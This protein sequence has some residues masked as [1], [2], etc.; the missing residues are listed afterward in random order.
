MSPRVSSKRTLVLSLGALTAFGPLSLDMYLPGLPDLSRDLGTT[1]SLAQ[2]TLTACMLGLAAG[3]LVAGPV[4]DARGRRA[5]LLV[6]LAAYAI[7][8]LLCALAP[9]IWVLIP[10]RF[11]QGF[12]GAAGIV[13]AR[14]IV[15]D[16]HTGDDAARF[17]S[18]L[19][20]VNGLAP[21]LAPIVGGQLLGV[22]DWRG[23]FVVLA[24][25]GVGLLFVGWRFVPETLAPADRHGGG[26]RAT[27]RVFGTLARDRAF[28]GYAL[29]AGCC[30]A[31]MFC[32]IAGS[33]FVLQDVFGL[34][35]QLFSVVFAV[36]ALGIVVAAQ[37]GARLVGRF[38][39]RRMLA[40]GLTTSGAGAAGLL[41]AVLLDAGLAG[42][43]PSFLLVVASVGLV[44]PNATALAL[45]GEPRIAGSA[46]ALLGLAQFAIGGAFAPL[47]GVG[48]S[49]TA[50]P[51][52]LTT[53]G[54]A[55]GSALAFG[56]LARPGA[57]AA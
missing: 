6:G 21:I 48:G 50:L 36:N 55:L 1:T 25:I 20:L 39:A 56:V 19:M 45:A 23:I 5:P 47:V 57:A 4:S 3:Q 30:T 54:L 24:A 17:Y 33:P 40:A 11:A 42:V 18:L 32:Y 16:L 26:L 28:A 53:A 46:S 44:T 38:G 15:R 22:T 8:S 13:I 52:A 34:S 37:I 31:M 14:A 51:L 43:L 2:L 41:L 27:T 10:L 12:A 49:G 9:S 35:P 7:A 29:A